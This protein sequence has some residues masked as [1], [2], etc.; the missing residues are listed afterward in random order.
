MGTLNMLEMAIRAYDPCISCATHNLDG[1]IATVL[2]ILDH[3]GK[4]VKTL[5]NY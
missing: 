4:R 5:R 2:N 1:S 3:N